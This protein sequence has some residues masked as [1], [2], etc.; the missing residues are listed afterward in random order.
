[1]MS[2]TYLRPALLAST[3][4]MIGMACSGAAMAQS[5]NAGITPPASPGTASVVSE[6][7]STPAVETQPNSSQLGDIVVTA[8]KR[9]ESILQIP[10]AISAISAQGIAARGIH[11]L[12]GLNDFVPGLRYENTAAN[13]NDRSFYTITM[14]GMY[15]GDAPN[16]PAVGVFLDGVSIPGGSLPGLTD[17]ER[18]EV[19]RGPQS[20]YFGR[21]TFA[22]AINFITVAPSLTQ[23]KGVAQGS[24]ESYG[25]TDDSISIE[26]PIITDRLAIRLTGRH[27]H[28]D[29]Q[30]K[31]E[32]YGG[33]LGERESNSFGAS[34]IA[35]PID[36]LT[37]RGYYSRWKD[38][39]GP[40]AQAALT[41]ADYNCD[42]G[43]TGRKVGGLNYICGG[44]GSIETARMS[45]NTLSGNNGNFT[46][47]TNSGNGVQSADYLTH[48]GLRRNEY[49][50]NTT[51]TLDLG[52][53][54]IAG[55]IGK[56]GNDWAVI[57]DTYNRPPDGHNYYSSVYLPYHIKNISSELRAS[58]NGTGP[59]KAM[60]GG[61]YYHESIIAE[62]RAL[63]PNA[64]GVPTVTQLSQPTD[65]LAT[66]YGIFGS[67][68]YDLTHR[69]TLSAEGRYQWDNIHHHIL[70]AAGFNQQQTFRS[71]NPRVIVNYKINP[72]VSLYASFAKGTRPGTFNSNLTSFTA[73]QQAQLV[74]NAGGSIPLAVPEETLR[75]YEVGVKGEFFD[76]RLRVL[77]DG[78]YGQWRH[79]QI[80]QNIAY[81]TAANTTST[82]TLTFPNGSTDLWG[83]EA[84]ATL[85]IT[86]DLTFDGTFNWA[87]TKVLNT[88]CAECVAINGIANP[89]GNLMERYPEFSG[90]AGISYS[91][92]VI[93][94]WNGTGRLDY[95]YTGKQYATEANV[96]YLKAAN[97]F[98]TS[99]G[100]ENATYRIEFFGR[101]IFN[102]KVPSNILRNANP[103]SGASEGG[104]LIV[105][106]A[107]EKAS[108]GVRGSVKF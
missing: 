15:P 41:E 54:T 61:N 98:N 29:G 26:G 46:Q 52:A 99:L 93:G 81:T 43:G 78:Y 9:G 62:G 19:V 24:Y 91:H 32:G 104:N 18:V 96:A 56:N 76:R 58:T 3:A 71:F 51:A 95:V 28:T 59:F 82:A 17:I 8:R 89:V 64:A 77:A 80:N 53:Y 101:N 55:S 23:F 40:S 97:R 72:L 1:M 42:A 92:P 108:F 63:R 60:I 86:R 4:A 36:A 57:T 13:R 69:L 20:A 12:N 45:Q 6:P 73:A 67:A 38:S 48:L 44:I 75:S 47:L 107:P 79:R 103:F 88:V 10:V 94:N 66:T 85:K 35:K 5:S 65:F 33:R 25:T 30:Y 27:Y 50:A 100:L 22:G 7:A 49:Q 106:A 90:T 70:T 87:H 21:A 34:I 2:A 105:L 83:I 68:S 39:D 14:R 74:A 16:R 31:N 84:E 11:D 37:I 102:N